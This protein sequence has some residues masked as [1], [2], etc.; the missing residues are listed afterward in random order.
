MRKCTAYKFRK[1]LVL[2]VGRMGEEM[3]IKLIVTFLI[4]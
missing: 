3:A 4:L 2:K 1:T